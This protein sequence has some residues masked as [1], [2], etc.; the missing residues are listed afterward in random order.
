LQDEELLV[1][2]RKQASDEVESGSVIGT[3]PAA[4]EEVECNS[5][6]TL[7]VSTGANLVTVPD[8]IGTDEALARSQLEDLHLIPDVNT[9]DDDA[10]EGTV[11]SQNPGPGSELKRNARVTLVVS[12]GAGSVV[13]PDVVGQAEDTARA[14]LQS[15]GLS[16]EVIEQETEDRGDD[17]RVLDQAPTSGTRAHSGDQVTIVVGVLVEPETTTTTPDTTTTTPDTTTTTTT[18]SP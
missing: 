7:I 13:V 18:T 8:L 2:T 15:A 16:V 11:I 4:E 12:T 1:R 14:N 6:V 3:D 5:A 17:G 9:R 10:P